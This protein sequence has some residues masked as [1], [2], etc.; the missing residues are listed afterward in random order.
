MPVSGYFVDANLLTLLVAGAGSP[1]H[2]RLHPGP[3]Q[4]PGN[5]SVFPRTRA[6]KPLPASETT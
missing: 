1:A 4:R 3:W 6:H 2:A 5:G